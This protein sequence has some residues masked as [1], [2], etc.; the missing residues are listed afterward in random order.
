MIYHLK[1]SSAAEEDMIT[2]FLWYEEQQKG[3]GEKF[4]FVISNLVEIIQKNPLAYQERYKNIRIAFSKKF[5]F[6]IHFYVDENTITILAVFHTSR[7]PK[8]WLKR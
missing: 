5:S 8:K 7:D 1:I 3:L 6:G 2:S 4:E